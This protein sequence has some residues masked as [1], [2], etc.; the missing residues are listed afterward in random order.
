MRKRKILRRNRKV[1][2]NH[3]LEDRKTIRG[4]PPIGQMV[5]SATV[6]RA[7][8]AGQ[9]GGREEACRSEW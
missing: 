2:R 8:F 6:K 7:T 3:G 1:R 5:Y 4:S 9:G